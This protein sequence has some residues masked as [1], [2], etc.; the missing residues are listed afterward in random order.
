MT[1]PLPLPVTVNR[2]NV[3]G[4]I[5]GGLV[6][7]KQLFYFF[8]ILDAATFRQQL[9]TFV[10]HITN[11]TKAVEQ[12]NDIKRHKK[13]GELGLLKELGVNIAFSHTGFEKMGID[14]SALTTEGPA[15]SFKAGQKK[16]AVNDLATQAK[17]TVLPTGMSI[18]SGT[19][20]ES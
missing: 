3:Q 2:D 19:Y 4:D 15:D 9:V 17:A 8:E 6:K 7:E 14:D 18:S 13:K 5:L 12:R 10:P 20:T 1:T 11:V 16:E